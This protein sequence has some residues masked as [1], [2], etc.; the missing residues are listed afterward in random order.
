MKSIGFVPARRGSKEIPLKNIKSFCGKPLIYW[1]LKSLETSPAIDEIILATDCQEIASVAEN[2]GFKK[3][4]IFMRSK[5]SASD[6]AATEVVMLEYIETHKLD[7]EHIFM[8]VQATTPFIKPDDIT[9]SLHQFK[10]QQADS[11]LSCA[12]THHFYWTSTGEAKN[13]DFNNRPRRQDFKGNL[14]ENGA[15]YIST[16]KSIRE[17]KNR[18]SGNISIYEMP[19]YTA[20]ELDN[21]YEWP[22]AEAIMRD[23]KLDFR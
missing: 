23:K 3:L 7:D 15:L 21:A 8:L 14:Q 18:L 12:R 5:E 19:N 16:I 20:L 9:E 22:I 17:S 6:T 10:S 2:F 1:T 4:Q 11:M 13:Y